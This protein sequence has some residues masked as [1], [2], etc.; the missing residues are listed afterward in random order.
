MVKSQRDF[1]KWTFCLNIC[2][3]RKWTE[4]MKRRFDIKLIWPLALQ[5][6]CQP[7]L[8]I[9]NVFTDSHDP[10]FPV[11]AFF[12]SRWGRGGRRRSH[13][14]GCYCLY[15]VD[16]WFVFSPSGRWTPALS[17]PGITLPTH[18]ENRKCPVSAAAAAAKDSLPSRKRC[19][20]CARLMVKHHDR[21]TIRK[22]IFFLQTWCNKTV[23]KHSFC[24]LCFSK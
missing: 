18:K 19:V 8:F 24:T 5:H 4:V 20:T 7:N 1:L 9:Q 6:S 11:I 23:W 15:S 17:S 16:N 10:G 22:C 3:R 13:D 2:L 14:D 12:T 21:K